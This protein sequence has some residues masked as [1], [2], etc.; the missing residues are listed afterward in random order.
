MITKKYLADGLLQLAILLSL[1]KFDLNGWNSF[2]SH[3]EIHEIVLGSSSAY[4]QTNFHSGMWN[5]HIGISHPKNIDNIQNSLLLQDLHS[6]G[7]IYRYDQVTTN[8]AW[9]GSPGP[10]SFS[11]NLENENIDNGMEEPAT[12]DPNNNLQ[13]SGPNGSNQ[14][15]EP[16]AYE[17]AHGPLEPPF[18]VGGDELTKEVNITT[19]A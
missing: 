7:E 9:L 3:P 17:N 6:L 8:I 5:D 16:V 1:M 12:P 10:G 15:E 14:G 2:I 19:L 11:G 13:E 18:P 4:T